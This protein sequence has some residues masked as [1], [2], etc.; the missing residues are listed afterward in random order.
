VK[1][2]RLWL[3]RDGDTMNIVW[4][5]HPE[6]AAL[7]VPT[8]GEL[9]LPVAEFLDELRAFDSR[10][11]AEMGERVRRLRAAGGRP[12]V[13]IDLDSLEWEQRDRATWLDTALARQ[14]EPEDLAPARRLIA[15]AVR[16]GVL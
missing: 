3:F 5:S 15:E 10:L 1:A 9:R 2:P 6:A 13:A 16:R 14:S 7:W 8:D 4:R 12:G 11:F